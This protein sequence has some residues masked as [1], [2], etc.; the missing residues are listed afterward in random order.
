MFLEGWRSGR[1]SEWQ[2]RLGESL[3]PVGERKW[4]RERKTNGD[5]PGSATVEKRL[6]VAAV[7][8][9]LVPG[10]DEDNGEFVAALRVPLEEVSGGQESAE[11]FAGNKLKVK[12]GICLNKIN[13]NVLSQRRLW[14]GGNCC[15]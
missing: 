8:Q 14:T 13:N 2:V 12:V 11:S 15:C 4:K 7:A 6:F 10:V 9:P 3:A 5:G 1:L